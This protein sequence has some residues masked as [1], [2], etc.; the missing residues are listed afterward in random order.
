MSIFLKSIYVNQL[1]WVKQISIHGKFTFSFRQ[2]GKMVDF[3]KTDK[4][5]KLNGKVNESNTYN[6]FSSN[7]SFSGE[8]L[9]W[10]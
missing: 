4:M 2:Y 3:D 5:I 7:I 6:G 10:I 1:I 9:P 8:V